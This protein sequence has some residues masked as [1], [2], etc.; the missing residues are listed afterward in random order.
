AAAVWSK[1][2]ASE[3]AGP[4]WRAAVPAACAIFLAGWGWSAAEPFLAQRRLAKQPGF[5]IEASPEVQALLEKLEAQLKTDP[6]SVD[7]AEHLGYLYARERA[8]EPAIARYR[9]VTQL[10]PKRPGPY[11]NLGNL[12]YSTGDL[13]KAVEEWK[14]SVELKPDQLDAHLN[15]GKALYEIGRLKESASHLEAAL[16]L[17][18]NNEKARVLLRKMVE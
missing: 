17:D 3:P 13:P 4:G 11:N 2:E 6:S 5:H 10:D 12:Y 16:R 14:R 1:P 7:V 18:P 9:L 8:W 15:L